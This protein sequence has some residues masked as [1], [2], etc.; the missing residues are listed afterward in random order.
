MP[1]GLKLGQTRRTALT[2]A[3][4]LPG[5]EKEL[6]IINCLMSYS[7]IYQLRLLAD[8]YMFCRCC[9]DPMEL[10]DAPGEPCD[11]CR[12]LRRCCA[13]GR[14]KTQMR[15]YPEFD[16]PMC[17]WCRRHTQANTTPGPV[18]ANDDAEDPRPC[19]RSNDPTSG[20]RRQYCW[21]CQNNLNDAS[22]EKCWLCDSD[23][24]LDSP[25]S[26]SPNAFKPSEISGA[27]EDSDV[28]KLTP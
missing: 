6:A 28:L 21:V 27:F 1:S 16:S 17:V 8:R 7:G 9:L 11:A 20:P 24:P 19:I 5:R 4:T 26:G 3:T 23:S 22:G 2:A 12:G 15:Q 14:N 10:V 18:A 25:G 13:C